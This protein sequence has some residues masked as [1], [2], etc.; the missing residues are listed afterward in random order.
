MFLERAIQSVYRQSMT[1]FIH[2]II[3]DGG[4]PK[5]VNELVEKYSSAT[6]GR[7]KIIHNAESHGMEAASNKAIKSVDSVAYMAIHDDDDTWH[8]DFLKLTVEK[9]DAG[10]MGVVARADKITE[11][12]KN[13]K[14]I[15]LKAEPWMPDMK[16]VNLYRQCI[17]NQLTPITFIYHRS[18]FDDIGYYDENLPVTGDWE[19]GVRFLQKYDVELLDPGYP[20][21]YYHHRK[22]IAGSG[23]NNS[24][25]GGTEKHR[26]YVNMVMNRY[27]RQELAE[28]RLGVGYIMSQLKYDRS[29]TATALKRV[30]PS[31]VVERIKKRVQN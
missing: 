15:Q 25:G 2:V 23:A 22:F 14:I 24:F 10:A 3:N 1:D 7:I 19:F 12:V 27:L 21:A 30:L 5:L 9:L 28:G 8:P 13:D 4:N 26:Y 29:N 11:E 18:V 20:L 31:F 17:D 16:V 6:K